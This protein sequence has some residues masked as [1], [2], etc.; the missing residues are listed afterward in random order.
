MLPKAEIKRYDPE[1]ENEY[2]EL[3]ARLGK[4]HSELANT[5]GEITRILTGLGSLVGSGKPYKNQTARLAELRQESEALELGAR[6]I[7]GQIGLLKRMHTWL[8]TR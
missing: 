5:E 7:D 3:S 4:L 6:H 1:V 8:R 2:N